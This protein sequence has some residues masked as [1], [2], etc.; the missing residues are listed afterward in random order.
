MRIAEVPV[1]PMVYMPE[2]VV[3]VVIANV[4]VIKAVVLGVSG[5]SAKLA[6]VPVGVPET[7]SVTVSG[8]AAGWT[9]RTVNAAVEPAQTSSCRGVIFKNVWAAAAA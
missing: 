6:S 4:V 9:T 8:V 2:T 5:F 1:T 7:E 3:L